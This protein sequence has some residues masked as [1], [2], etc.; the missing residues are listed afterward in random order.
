MN[1]GNGTDSTPTLPQEARTR[2]PQPWP[3][4]GHA[5][6]LA[7]PNAGGRE[8]TVKRLTVLISLVGLA[9]LALAPPVLAAPPSNDDITSP[10]IV[11][12]LPYTD[13][14]YDTTEATTGASDPDKCFGSPDRSTVWYYLYADR[15]WLKPQARSAASTTRRS[16]S[17]RRMDRAGSTSSP[18]T[19]T[20]ATACNRPSAGKRQ[21]ASVPVGGRD[22]LRWRCCRR[23]RRRR[24][25][26]IPRRR[27]IPATDDRR[28]GRSGRASESRRISDSH[29]HCHVQRRCGILR[30]IDVQL[31]PAVGRFSVDG[32]GST[33]DLVCDGTAQPWSVD[34]FAKWPVQGR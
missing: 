29:W 13:G 15:I 33:S 2:N 1:A 21:A 31:S 12:T 26:R 11:G 20:R 19:T 22:L 14:P 9:T 23:G 28:H 3:P 24:D 10:T 17:A 25:A 6:P 16:T 30:F 27:R 7:N 18:A 32:F 8:A 34:V 5:E 4:M